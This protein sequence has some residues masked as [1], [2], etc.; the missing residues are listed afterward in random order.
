MTDYKIRSEPAIKNSVLVY[1]TAA[2]FLCLTEFVSDFKASSPALALA[3]VTE[4]LVVTYLVYQYPSSELVRV[5][6]IAS[7]YFFIEAHFFNLPLTFH[8]VIYWLP[9]VPVVAL[10]VQNIRSACI[11]GL[12]VLVTHLFNYLYT[13]SI[14]DGTY[15]IEA[16]L[17]S[18]LLTG[19]I[20]ISLM[21]ACAYLLYQL[22]GMA[23]SKV[24]TKNQELETLRNEIEFKNKRLTNYQEILI[25]LSKDKSIY[26]Q[27]ENHLFHVLCRTVV[28]TLEINRASVWI[29]DEKREYLVRKYIYDEA[30]DSDE[31]V[32]L[33][34]AN[35]P[36]YF[37]AIYNKAYIDASDALLHPDTS[38]F[39]SS[40]LKPLNI[41]SML[42]CP[43]KVDQKVWGV[44]CCE[45]KFGH[46][47]WEIEDILFVQS[48]ADLIALSFKNRRIKNLLNQ[49]QT[50]NLDLATK[51]QAIASMN[52][53]LNELNEKLQ[54]ANSTLEEK[55]TLRTRTLK[56]KN[57][58]LTE[59]AFI[60][61]HLLRAPLARVLG[62]S[63]LIAREVHLESDKVLIQTLISSTE[64]LD[65][66]IKKISDLLYDGEGISREDIEQIVED[67]LKRL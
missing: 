8:V 38:E 50:N 33:L 36:A 19:A 12:V 43:I 61:S 28:S 37:Q 24:M 21:I 15:T 54:D 46:R 16:S 65:A 5:I 49:L 20:F 25:R 39:S 52:G 63:Q 1:M 44:I 4:A 56:E 17:P 59:Y 7:I 66:I 62:L 45:N 42:D 14:T 29:L 22:L 55:V 3:F 51:N 31:P 10:I 47:H 67:K 2:L 64:E 11:W 32:S 9:L 58:L 27:G 30:E 6:L 53:Q 13:D 40:Y 23:Y 35:Y 57:K 41:K 60:N 48:I 34:A 18:Y 26:R